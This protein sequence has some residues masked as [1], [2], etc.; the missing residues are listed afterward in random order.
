MLRKG[1]SLIREAFP[2]VHKV[3]GSQQLDGAN[4]HMD[5]IYINPSDVVDPGPSN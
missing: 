1:P 2:Y 5:M 4:F 3:L